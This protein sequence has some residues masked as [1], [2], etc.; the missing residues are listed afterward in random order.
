MHEVEGRA[1]QDLRRP[2]LASAEIARLRGLGA[3][4]VEARVGYSILRDPAGLLFCVVPVQTG[5]Q[6][7]EAATWG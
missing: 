6:F 5:E 2:H 3:R 1:R 4:F 7:G